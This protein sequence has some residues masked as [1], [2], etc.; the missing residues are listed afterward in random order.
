MWKYGELEGGSVD[1]KGKLMNQ[2]DGKPLERVGVMFSLGQ[3]LPS[4]VVLGSNFGK[5]LGV[6]RTF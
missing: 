4:I 1:R 2:A 6:V 3:D 5:I